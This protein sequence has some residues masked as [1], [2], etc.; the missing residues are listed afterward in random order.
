L[1]I[2][3]NIEKVLLKG[4]AIAP[5]DLKVLE[6]STRAGIEQWWA[7]KGICQEMHFSREIQTIQH[8]Y[9][10]PVSAAGPKPLGRQIADAI[11]EG[12]AGETGGG[13]GK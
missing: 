6:A 11:L 12:I 1:K 3:I 7:S 4:A 9:L 8:R 10:S 2:E 13:T 5:E